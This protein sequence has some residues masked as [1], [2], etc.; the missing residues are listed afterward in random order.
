MVGDH[1]D[2]PKSEFL[3]HHLNLVFGCFAPDCSPV[4]GQEA[5]N[6]LEFGKL[7]V[8]MIYL[9]EKSSHLVQEGEQ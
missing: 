5:R 4:E 2:G 1:R 7:F 6:S 8:Y 3:G 9:F